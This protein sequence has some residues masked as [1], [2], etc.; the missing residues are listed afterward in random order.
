ML[1]CVTHVSGLCAGVY[2]RHM[3]MYISVCYTYVSGLCV[4]VC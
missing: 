3:S 1:V 2:V 4:G